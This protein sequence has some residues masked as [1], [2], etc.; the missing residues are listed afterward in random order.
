MLGCYSFGQTDRI[1]SLKDQLKQKQPDS[2]R[3]TILKN[4]SWEFLNNRLNGELAKSYIDSIQAISSRNQIAWGLALAQYQ[5]AVLDR[6]Q[7]NYGDALI[8]IQKYLDY[9]IGLGDE[10]AVADGLYQKA[11]VLDD[12]G[13]FEES[14]NLYQSIL[15]NYEQRKD[16]FSIATT[17][18]A[19]GEI[20]KKTG[21]REEAMKSYTHALTLFQ[22]QG[23]KGEM[24]NCYFNIG[25]TYLLE[26]KYELALSYF[27]KSLVLDQQL[28]SDWG[29]AYDYEAIGK[30]KQ[31]Q[32]TYL[33]ALKYHSQAL[34][35]RQQLHQKRELGM[36]YYEMGVNQLA[37]HQYEQ[38]EGMLKKA[39][40]LSSEIGA[41]EE[42]LKCYDAISRLYE[43]TGSL[44]QALTYRDRYIQV[45][46]SL[47]N[48]AKSRQIEELFIRF[49]TEKKQAAIAD[50]EKD[51]Q[52]TDLQLKREATYRYI[53][54]GLF[55]MA[56]LFTFILFNRYTY[57]QKAVREREE[58]KRVIA[59]EKR[60]TEQEKKRVQELQQIDKLKDEFLA[61]TSHELRTP[62]HGII[63]LSES[64]KDGIAGNLPPMAIKSLDMISNSGKRL[65]H[66]VNDLLD[67]SKLKNND[68]ELNRQPVD[69]YTV[70]DVVLTLSEPLIGDRKLRLFN[71][72]PKD[73]VLVDADENRLQ[74]ILHNLIGN[75]IKF[76]S[77]GEVTVT[78]R[79]SSGMLEVAVSDTGIGIPKDQFERIFSSFEQIDGSA[80]RSYGGTGL[81]LAVTRQLV[82]LHGGKIE[83]SSEPG[84]G[85]VFR[86]TLPISEAKRSAGCTN[87]PVAA[88]VQQ[89]TPYPE[90]D[91][92][93]SEDIPVPV[94]RQQG[95]ILV[96]DDEPVNR[97][98]LRNHLT[99]VGYEV[100]EVSNGKRALEMLASERSFD[101]VLLDIMMP[102]LS[103][104]EVCE[105]IRSEYLTSELPV[106]LLTAKNRVSDLVNAFN[107]G[108]NDY[109][110]KPFSKSELLSRIR[111]HLHLKGI[112]KAASRFVPTEFIKSVGRDAITD[113]HLGDHVEKEVTVLFSDIR[114]Y[115][116]L[117]ESMTPSQNFKFVNSYVGKMGPLVNE[118]AGFISQYFGDGIMALFPENAE[119]A[120]KAAV[121][122]Q[123]R[124]MQYNEQ[125][126][127]KG[128]TP[129]AIG[130][131]LHTGT[132]VMGIIGDV[133]RNDTAIISDTVNTASRMEGLTKYYGARI[134]LSESSLRSIADTSSYGL[135]Y[136]GK[137][138]VKG[139]GKALGIYECYDGDAAD[140]RELKQKSLK[141]F[142]KG[143]Q[144][145]FGS[146]FPRATAVFDGI[147]KENP[148]DLVAKYFVTRAAQFTLSGKMM[149]DDIINTMT[150]K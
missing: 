115:T 43:E 95:H 27:N 129:L 38:A 140:C 119:Q 39:I 53:I 108:A 35:L 9:W 96:V 47:F 124:L 94:R 37:L 17:L 87:K 72:I 48:E 99:N 16:T 86:F 24:A 64:L 83:V 125:R 10:N 73:L 101:L 102:G 82:E 80:Q 100:T 66:L 31:Q 11:I 132:L 6:Q 123:H 36:S 109:L 116:A 71:K 105:K 12:I 40:S 25:D 54:I 141:K 13:D 49:D 111:T 112:H 8:A 63:G 28:K 107:L 52:I 133:S 93:V 51:A 26:K 58:K 15:K 57:K 77:Q 88:S 19:L 1:D 149:E 59:E 45:K 68:L 91:E 22:N 142:D 7:G 145:F 139:K 44:N 61:N 2:V 110:T 143:L 20:L 127:M 97:Q 136:L 98:V 130:I 69:L 76:T 14:L 150:E 55:L 3:I 46:D 104:F 60:K 134:I 118:N 148:K 42:L 106:V 50:L 85:S 92:L 41:K 146:E 89:L 79:E 21:R 120:L 32:G 4:L 84:K 74:Q 67:F 128:Y 70:T 56:L 131:G 34:E 5:Y 90:A 65:A 30:V 78:A 75:A 62:L 103:G 29:M 121:G 18:N 113:V 122:M 33:E 23:D 138:R 81:G 144:H 135:R 126:R 137:V 147:L 117:A 114:D